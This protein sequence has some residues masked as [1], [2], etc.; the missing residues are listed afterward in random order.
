MPFAE[1][2]LDSPLRLRCVRWLATLVAF[3]A[4]LAAAAGEA[5]A[6]P[7]RFWGVVPQALPNLEQLDRLHRGGARSIRVPIAWGVVQPRRHSPSDWTGVDA[8][9]RNLTRSG[10]EFLPVLHGAPSWAVRQ[11]AVPGSGGAARAPR[12]LPAHGRAAA[13]W[14]RFVHEAVARYGSGG[15]FWAENPDL[16]RRP[17]R[18]WQ[19]WNEPNFKYFV[20]RPNPAEYG[21]LVNLSYAAIRSADRQGRI[22]LAGLFARPA[23]AAR[24]YR[25]P[26]AYFA[27]DFLT[28]M[29]RSTP[30][31]RHRFEAIALHPYGGRFQYLAPQIDEV[32]EVLERNRDQRKALWITELGWSS[33]RP[34]PGN[35]FAKGR[36]GQAR[37]LAGAFAVLRRNQRRWHLQ[38]VYW[39]SVDD[40]AGSCNFCDGSGL[41]GAG[42]RPKP[43]WHSFVRFAGGS[44]R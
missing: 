38:R 20:A 42:F 6:L 7:A 16:A 41:F 5:A 22:V 24:S 29:Y 8:L 18:F 25:P 4:L 9:V 1:G 44:V 11:V 13:S 27:T 21:R 28:R 15:S 17:V 39:F 34:T 19:I 10:F 33:Q 23:E 36:R 32:R 43:A 2:N 31:I 40:Q 26:R 35:S 3:L 14:R 12:N 37:Q 30:G